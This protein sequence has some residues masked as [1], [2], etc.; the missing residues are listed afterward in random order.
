M[1]QTSTDNNLAATST[2]SS[3]ACIATYTATEDEKCSEVASQ[4]N[5][6]LSTYEANTP[7]DSIDCQD[8]LLGYRV[9]LASNATTSSAA[10]V[11]PSPTLAASNGTFAANGTAPSNATI[12]SAPLANNATAANVTI[13]A[14][15]TTYTVGPPLE[16]V[17]L[18][19]TTVTTL[20]YTIGTGTSKAQRTTKVTH[21]STEEMDVTSSEPAS[22]AE[23]SVV[24]GVLAT[25]DATPTSSSVP[26]TT[27][28]SASTSETKSTG[29]VA[30]NAL[31]AASTTGQSPETL[32]TCATAAPPAN[33]QASAITGCTRWHVAKAGEYCFD[34]AD[35]YNL[36]VGNFMAMNP[37]VGAPICPNLLT[38]DAY[39]VATCDGTIPTATAVLL[40]SLSSTQSSRSIGTPMAA[41]TTL[42]MSV[43]M[44]SSLETLET[45]TTL[46]TL[47]RPLTSV[48]A[49]GTSAA[50]PSASV[51]KGADVYKTY[52]GN[53]SVADGWPA[54]DQWVDFDDM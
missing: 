15:N 2:L 52:K 53:G 23:V 1:T 17:I 38:G 47:T 27:S 45:L 35:E 42:T 13:P 25:P 50:A 44:T 10:E 9:C 31:A 11:T 22:T 43:T 18:T 8:L 39:C 36:T 46:S 51:T 34:V 30:A 29:S 19:H 37:A 12:T 33:T 24:N 3:P 49:A 5:I 32:S 20:T 14:G 26:E 16:R 21:T 41:L 6:Q 40:N 48:V 54:Q 4:Y 7:A 28:S